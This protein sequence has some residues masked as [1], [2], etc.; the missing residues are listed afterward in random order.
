MPDNTDD[1]GLHNKRR[2]LTPSKGLGRI[3]RTV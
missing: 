1:V 2:V 3:H